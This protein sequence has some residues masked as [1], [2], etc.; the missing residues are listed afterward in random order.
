MDAFDEGAV[1]PDGVVRRQAGFHSE[2]VVVFTV[3][4]GGVHHAGA[5]R[6]R[7]PIGGQ[8]RPGR[9]G[10]TTGHGLG[11][12]RMVGTADEVGP[13]DAFDDLDVVAQHLAHQV[14]SEDQFLANGGATGAFP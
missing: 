9:G 13:L 4:D 8:H 11:E 3:H 5:V 14:L 6:G 7:D 2:V 12:E 10:F 1:H